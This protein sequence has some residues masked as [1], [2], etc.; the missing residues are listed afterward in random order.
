MRGPLSGRRHPV[1]RSPIC[2]SA[3]RLRCFR[4]RPRASSPRGTRPMPPNQ[5]QARMNGPLCVVLVRPGIPKVDQ[6]SIAHVFRC[7]RAKALPGLRDALLIGRDEPRGG[8]QGPCEPTESDD[9]AVTWRRSA[10][11][12]GCGFGVFDAVPSL[13][14]GVLPLALLQRAAMASSSFVT[15][16]GDANFLQVVMR[17]ARQKHFVDVVLAKDRLALRTA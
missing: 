15:K 16:R 1:D 2:S 12:S 7:E 8:L 13:T 5:L 14:D 4:R 17:P 10:R 3:L 6:N 11:S 9:I